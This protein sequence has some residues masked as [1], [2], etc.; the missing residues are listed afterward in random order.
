MQKR[1][2]EILKELLKSIQIGEGSQEEWQ[3][4]KENI[5]RYLRELR[6]EGA[7]EMFLLYLRGEY[8]D[9]RELYKILLRYLCE[10]AKEDE[11]IY[12]LLYAK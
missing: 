8:G 1:F 10:F 7:L 2:I 12:E 4:I 9:D 3:Q 11:I 5:E 6:E